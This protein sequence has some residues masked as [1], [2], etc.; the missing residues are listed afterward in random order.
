MPKGSKQCPY[1][2]KEVGPRSFYCKYCFKGLL[3]KGVQHP[4]VVPGVVPKMATQ[5]RSD[6][7]VK[8]NLTGVVTRCYDNH[9]LHILHKFYKRGRTWESKDGLFRIRYCPYFLGVSQKLDEGKPFKVLVK[10]NGLWEPLNEEKNRFKKLRSAI[11][12]VKKLSKQGLTES[13]ATL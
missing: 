11:K 9:E 12:K 2:L 8:P 10:H 5:K 7:V 6:I 3:V 1:C 4:D 13:K